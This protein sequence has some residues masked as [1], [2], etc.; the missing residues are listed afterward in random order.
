MDSTD[1]AGTTAKAAF[2]NIPQP[3]VDAYVFHMNG[4]TDPLTYNPF[5]HSSPMIPTYDGFIMPYEKELSRPDDEKV[6]IDIIKQWFFTALA[7]S[8]DV[9]E[10][11]FQNLKAGWGIIKETDMG[12][13]LAHLYTG[14]NL[15]I[16][17]GARIKVIYG[18]SYDGFL[19]QGDHFQIY[20]QG[21]LMDP[22][23]YAE[24]VAD[25]DNA[26]PHTRSLTN[27]L[28]VLNYPDD[29]ARNAALGTIHSAHDLKREISTHG[30]NV[31]NEQVIK[32]NAQ[33]LVFPH[34]P[35][36]SINAHNIVLV[37]K[38]MTQAESVD[39]GFPLH[40]LYLLSP[41][42]RHRLWSSFGAHA[43]TFL[44]PNGRHVELTG[45]F[46]WTEKVR[47][48]KAKVSHSITRMHIMVVELAD[49]MRDLDKMFAD[50]MVY[51]PLGTPIVRKASSNS[52]LREFKDNSA[53]DILASLRTAAGITVTGVVAQN[54]K[55]KAG[56]QGGPGG[57]KKQ[58][59][60]SNMED[61]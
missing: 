47:A 19:L 35:F 16:V 43:P 14:I 44:I 36:L 32:Q 55:R 33:Y 38:A 60:D 40:P 2:Y 26:V 5:V 10:V 15:A 45:N 24:L 28:A 17:T 1:A 39:A 48:G 42:R 27:I 6:V 7:D 56:N 61:V 9:A 12:E 31:N 29:V 4:L 59:V 25:M 37:L 18:T 46:T 3:S 52:V 34:Q 51:S 21:S 11:V 53:T 30:Y 41:N 50:K 49:A 13:A 20:H 58:K 54:L 23:P 8:A 57:T 22:A